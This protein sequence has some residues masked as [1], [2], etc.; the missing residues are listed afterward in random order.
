[1]CNSA[2][3]P[4]PTRPTLTCAI[5]ALLP[6][7]VHLTAYGLARKLCAEPFGYARD[8]S[9]ASR[10]RRAI[11]S[12]ARKIRLTPTPLVL[13]GLARWQ[14]EPITF[15][16]RDLTRRE[17]IADRKGLRHACPSLRRPAHRADHDV[18][19]QD[20]RWAGPEPACRHRARAPGRGRKAGERTRKNQQLSEAGH[21]AKNPAARS[22][23]IRYQLSRW[24]GR[25][26][27]AFRCRAGVSGIGGK[28][29]EGKRKGGQL[30]ETSHRTKRPA[31]RS[32][33]IRDQLPGRALT[34]TVDGSK[35]S[36]LQ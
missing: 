4:H 13:L 6:G 3:K 12:I 25:T 28:K 32:A 21:R 16:Y 30:P 26:K 22:P 20:R 10:R 18:G 36:C 33:A 8:G 29:S 11:R 2:T 23:P 15:R 14:S 24:H 31:P 34:M 9:F 5:A 1:M 35:A 27:S 17:L 19:S 7:K